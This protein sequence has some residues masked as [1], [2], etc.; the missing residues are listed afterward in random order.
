MGSST[1]LIPQNFVSVVD[2]AHHKIVP[3]A[4][5][6]MQLGHHPVGA[7]DLTIVGRGFRD[8]KNFEVVDQ[9]PSNCTYGFPTRLRGLCS[10][11]QCDSAR[12]V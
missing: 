7:L 6:V 11:P 4:V 3:A 12:G 5:A 2:A 8:T 10:P 9:S 1:L